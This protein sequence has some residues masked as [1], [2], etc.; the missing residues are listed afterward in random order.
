MA[1]RKQDNKPA[2]CPK[3]GSLHFHQA[4]FRRY[5]GEMYSSA[6]GGDLSAISLPLL[7]RICVCGYPIPDIPR[8]SIPVEERRLFH[9]SATAALAYLDQSD[10]RQIR[11]DLAKNFATRE[12]L[13]ELRKRLERF[14][15]ILK[16]IPGD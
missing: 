4:E 15:S 9:A 5:R 13:Q 14:D 12:E 6:P 10:S 16:L 11:K 2:V 3:C 8:V 7:A 1:A